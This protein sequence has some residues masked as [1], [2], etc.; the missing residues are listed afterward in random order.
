MQVPSDLFEEARALRDQ[1][2]SQLEKLRAE[3]A[4]AAPETC[5]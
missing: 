3:A 1:A 5:A 4:P 2:D